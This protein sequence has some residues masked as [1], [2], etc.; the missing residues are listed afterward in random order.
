MTFGG[1][2]HSKYD[3]ELN[4]TPLTD[5]E[6]A[7][8][9]VGIDQSVTYGGSPVLPVSAGILD[10]GT[11]LILLA[12]DAF[13]RY[14]SYTGGVLDDQIG[15]LRITPEQYKNLQSLY[16]QIGGIRYELTPN[17]QIWPRALNRAI[18]GSPHH[19]YLIVN[20]LGTTQG[21]GLDFINGM[22][23]LERFYMVYDI[24]NNRVG[25][26]TT[27]YTSKEIN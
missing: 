16:F 9:Y 5:Q 6:P 12:S 21:I 20:D 1:V 18:G 25:L 17:A 8:E 15:L 24:G 10:T 26:A 2:D 3:G 27:E 22:A 13:Q 23:F 19:L 4:W 14:Q 11:T 7:R